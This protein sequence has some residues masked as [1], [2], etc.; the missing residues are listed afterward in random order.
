[1]PD[2]P[3]AIQ[4]SSDLIEFMNWGWFGFSWD[5]EILIANRVIA[6]LLGV[7]DR[8]ALQGIKLWDLCADS[9]AQ[10][11][12]RNKIRARK[13]F[14][15]F[16]TKLRCCD[17]EQL[18][19]SL[20]MYFR[21]NGDV[22]IADCLVKPISEHWESVAGQE[23]LRSIAKKQRRY[24]E[25]LGR[26]IFSAGALQ[27]LPA[28][29]NLVCR[30]AT[31]S[32][33][34]VCS[35]LW[36]VDDQDLVCAAA[37]GGLGHEVVG[38]KIPLEA[39]DTHWIKALN[40]KSPLV[41]SPG[42]LQGDGAVGLASIHPVLLV[43]V[44]LAGRAVGVFSLFNDAGMHPIDS[45]DLEFVLQLGTHAA[46]TVE[47]SRLFE[48]LKVAN[49]NIAQAYDATL[50]GWARALEIRDRETEGHS[51]RVVDLALKLA[52]LFGLAEE[53]LLHVY[54]GAL[55]HDIGKMGIPDSILLKK[56]P[57][58]PIEQKIMQK[59]PQLAYEMLKPIEYLRLALDIPYCHHEKWDGTGYPRG[60]K[61]DA[62]PLSARI[63]AVVDVWDALSHVR[64]YHKA[65]PRAK[66][67]DEICAQSGKHF[68]PQ[69]VEKFL[70][71]IDTIP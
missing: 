66:I 29:L 14:R 22:Q 43:P 62:I 13:N 47:N 70:Q 55:L 52:Y 31:A 23:N 24:A 50:A 51:Q 2:F 37:D 45:D 61:G 56:G 4:P 57:L 27:N 54:R 6:D 71:L 64:P 40:S 12:L 25:A 19:C 35:Q 30:E 33:K 16:E 53:E 9:A 7:T 49:H 65:W 48:S 39:V 8:A 1:M 69:V 60:L 5:G 46:M 15:A 10:M 32:L 41:L 63:F 42:S 58:T 3:G 20:D 34:V 26:M 18:F 59:H 11:A 17:G 36:L 21:P 67:V 44:S 38:K 28:F 68:D